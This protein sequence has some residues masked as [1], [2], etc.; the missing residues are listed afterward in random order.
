MGNLIPPSRIAIKG[1]KAVFALLW[2]EISLS[3]QYATSTSSGM[4]NVCLNVAK[5]ASVFRR[6]ALQIEGRNSKKEI[7][8]KERGREGSKKEKDFGLVNR[9]IDVCSVE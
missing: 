1:K 6:K 9:C 2:R 7:K 4:S 5:D 3:W 8:V